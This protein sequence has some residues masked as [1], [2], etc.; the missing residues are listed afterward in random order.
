MTVFNPSG[1]EEE[2]QVQIVLV[3][4]I[5]DERANSYSFTEVSRTDPVYVANVDESGHIQAVI[6]TIERL[7][8]DL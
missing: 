1:I 3:K 7:A 2:Y 4:R 6:S 8:K 5:Y